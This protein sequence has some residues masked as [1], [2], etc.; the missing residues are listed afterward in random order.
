MLTDKAQQALW[1]SALD[2][3]RLLTV[4]QKLAWISRDGVNSIEQRLHNAVKMLAI[5]CVENSLLDPASY[6]V[7]YAVRLN[8]TYADSQINAQHIAATY[9]EIYQHLDRCRMQPSSQ[10]IQHALQMV[11]AHYPQRLD[12]ATMQ[13]LWQHHAQQPQLLIQIYLMQNQWLPKSYAAIDQI[14]ASWGCETPEQQAAFLHW[15]ARSPTVNAD[16]FIQLAEQLNP[17]ELSDYGTLS[18]TYTLLGYLFHKRKYQPTLLVE[19]L[20]QHQASEH[21]AELLQVAL[22]TGEPSLQPALLDFAKANPDPG[23]SWLW[24]LGYRETADY[25]LQQLANVQWA[26][27][28][29]SAWHGITGQLL[30]ERIQLQAIN[31]RA[32]AGP[33]VPDAQQAQRWWHNNA[34]H[35]PAAVTAV[36]QRRVLGQPCS[37]KLLIQAADVTAGQQS[38]WLWDTLACQLGHP[39]G[40]HAM[41]RS[42]AIQSQLQQIKQQ[43]LKASKKPHWPVTHIA[44]R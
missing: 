21:Y 38:Q 34:V 3:Y 35:W 22:L 39:V 7:H 18:L 26:N 2:Y 13:W 31:G 29:A 15:A 36:E 16:N 27:Q 9:Q 32:G 8:N 30:K 1:Q 14:I 37:A 6:Y 5:Q 4:R 41:H 25:A 20:Q 23:L 42:A 24:L 19:L 43:Q 40:L 10:G 44:M 11:L 17:A 28:A 33:L 12:A